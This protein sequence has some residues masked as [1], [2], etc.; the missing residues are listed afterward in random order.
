RRVY[1]DLIGL[2]PTIE[3]ADA[4]AKDDS[5]DA[6]NKLVDELLKSPKYGERWARPWLDLARYSDTNGYEKDRERSIW[7]WRD[8][9]I[10]ALNA[11]M[12]YDQFSIEQLAGDMLPNPTLDQLTATGFH[13]NTML[14]EEGGIDPLEYR[15]YAVVDRVATTGTVWLGLTTGCAQCHTHKYDP[16]THEDYY[17][18]F[19]LLNNADEPDLLLK[20]DAYRG[21]Q[22]DL[23]RQIDDLTAKLPQQFPPADGD[24]PI[25]KRR[26]ANLASKFQTWLESNRKAAN[27]W[28]TLQPEKMT[29][30]LPRLEL[31]DDGSIFS[32]GDV[33]KRDV[34]RLEFD[35]SDTDIVFPITA[36]RLEAIPDDRLPAGGP[37]RA[38]YEGRKGDFFLS[39]LTAD[40]NGNK[41]RLEKPSRSYGKIAIGSGNGEAQNVLDGNGST[42][43]S[44]AQREGESHQLVVNLA[45]P[46][47]T[48]GR[49][50][51]EML[52]ERH[53]VAALGRFR[54]SAASSD[55]DCQAKTIPVSIERRIAKSTLNDSDLTTLK[56]Y[57]L[58]VAEDLKQ[59]NEKIAKL[60]KRM[61]QAP[62]TMVM[63]ERPLDNPRQTHRHHRGEYLSPRES[64]TP[65]VPSFL[66]Q[67]SEST[68]LQKADQVTNRLELAR[69][70]VSREKPLAARVAVNRAWQEFFGT[71]LLKTS[72][73]FGTQSPSPSHPELLD[74]LACEFMDGG[75]SMKQLHRTIVLSNT[76][77]QSAKATANQKTSDPENLLLSH[78]PRHRVSG[79]SVRDI[80]LHASGLLSAKMYGPSVRPPQPVSVVK[81]AYG[82]PGWPVA[83]GE[84]RYRRSL[85]TFSKRTAPFAAYV[86]FDAPS[87][88]NCIARRDRSN[89]PLQALTLLNDKMYLEMAQAL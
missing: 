32:S 43:W 89:T 27:N 3:Q 77:Q 37:G 64:V 5:P 50:V 88:E 35:L 15:F 72:G 49:L 54:F 21:K 30:N 66:T 41:L 8:W 82:N 52:F 71:G 12:P 38:Y 84:D 17:R 45:D 46:I 7:P 86:L 85:Y 70:L 26:A 10:R 76:Y 6:Y 81:V 18:F 68:Q 58:T 36:L 14:N 20:D 40:F 4:F 29:S 39:E 87:G 53:F 47:T 2:P 48:P 60:R 73:D 42:G 65:G 63:Q 62:T 1:L 69:W 24:D 16:I 74:W 31:L 75:W 22:R 83:K 51:I 61:N 11:D 67:T 57:F 55:A 25:E 79:E 19:A 80:M 34:Y 59:P 44:T 28:H 33:T 56:Q 23:Q 9:V 13:R 78:F